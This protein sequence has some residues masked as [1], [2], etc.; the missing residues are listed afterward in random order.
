M[1]MHDITTRLYK[2][3]QTAVN[4]VVAAALLAFY[5]IVLTAISAF[6]WLWFALRGNKR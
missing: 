2:G 5:C 3:V 1:K 4:L 6:L